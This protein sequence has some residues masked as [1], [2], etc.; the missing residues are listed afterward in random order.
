MSETN[1]SYHCPICI[2]D[3]T[4]EGIQPFQCLHKLCNDCNKNF[5]ESC[6]YYKCPICKSDPKKDLQILNSIDDDDNDDDNV[7]DLNS[8]RFF[9]FIEILKKMFRK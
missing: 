5:R 7:V 9:L 3:F 8:L 6:L 2:N 1:L 4:D